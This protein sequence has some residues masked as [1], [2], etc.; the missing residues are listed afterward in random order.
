MRKMKKYFSLLLSTELFQGMHEAD[1][2]AVLGCLQAEQTAVMKNEIVLLAGNKPEHLGIVLSGALHIVKEDIDGNRTLVAALTAGDFFAETLLCAG[3][4]ESPVTVY[5]ETD[6][7][8]VLLRFERILH[9]CSQV[10]AF[11]AR[12]IQ[13][14][15]AIVARKNLLLQNRMEIISIKSIRM[16]VLRYLSALVP[17][18]GQTITIPF[19][20][21]EMAN[22]LCVE[23]SALSHELTRMKK[24]GLIDYQKNRFTLY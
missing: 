22:Y 10:C 20:R 7:A 13:N 17:E 3:V 11:H 2:R 21:E 5:A 14:L 6:A 19:N 4:T 24:E 12:L 8:I 9:P 18:H 1:L 16:K 15:L 23:R